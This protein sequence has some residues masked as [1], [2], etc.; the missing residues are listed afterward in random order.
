MIDDEIDDETYED[1]I[2]VKTV[3]KFL[4]HM[5]GCWDPEFEPS[6][7]EIMDYQ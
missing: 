4:A 5:T 6:I 2:T 1:E 3:S 7:E